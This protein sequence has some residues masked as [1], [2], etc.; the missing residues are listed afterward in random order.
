[1]TL[2][3]L[4]FRE[5]IGIDTEDVNLYSFDDYISNNCKHNVKGY[6]TICEDKGINVCEYEEN[7]SLKNISH[8]S[9]S[10]DF[11]K[12]LNQEIDTS[13]WNDS[14]VVFL[15]ESPSGDYGIYESQKYLKDDNEYEKRP[16][17]QW[18]WIHEKHDLSVYPK[19]FKGSEYG[20]FVNSAIVTFK[21]SNAYMTNL[22]KCGMNDFTGKRYKGID[23]YNSDCIETCFNNYFRKELEIM[24]PKVIFTF[25]SKVYKYVSNKL[26]DENIKVVG[27]PHPAGQRRGFKDE[28]YNV[29][30]FCLIA[31]WL[32]KT[33]VI[34]EKF[35]NELMVMFSNSD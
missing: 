29:L 6:C 8:G 5:L 25:G 31:K 1:M 24:E 14:G 27:L 33:E 35:Y 10:R 20:N 7:Y 13:G 2:N 19:Y 30:Y 18:Y 32:R 12:S 3:E 4:N 21:L 15:M 16:A 22:I 28:Y 23:Y 34:D 17:K 26:S 11:I 9:H